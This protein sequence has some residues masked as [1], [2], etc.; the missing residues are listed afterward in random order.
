MNEIENMYVLSVYNK[1]TEEFNKTRYN[2]WNYVKNFLI[3]I[4]EENDSNIY[5]DNLKFLDLGCGNGKYLSFCKNFE[6]YAVDNCEKL[7]EIVQ[8][9]YPNVKTIQEDVTNVFDDKNNYFDYII[10]IAVIHHLSDEKRRLKMIENM[11]KLLKIGGNGLITAWSDKINKIK[12]KKLDDDN[13]YLIPWQNEYQRYYHLFKK[14]ELK[15]LL[16]K[17]KEKIL[18]IEEKEECNNWILLFKRIK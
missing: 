9:K 10:C 7:L 5:N 15:N 18:I 8:K 6:T 12:Y 17:F 2:Y 1:I 3:R 16:L 13:N 4:N 11:L 14:D